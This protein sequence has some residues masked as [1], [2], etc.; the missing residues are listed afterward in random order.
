MRLHYLLSNAL[1]CVVC[2]ICNCCNDITIVNGTVGLHTS[3]VFYTDLCKFKQFIDKKKD[4]F[5]V[6]LQSEF[7]V[8]CYT[9]ISCQVTT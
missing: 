1:K 6:G 9:N 3:V 2:N 7:N 4:T 8:I 5:T